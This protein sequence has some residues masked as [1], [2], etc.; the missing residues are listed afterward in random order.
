MEPLQRFAS[1]IQISTVLIVVPMFALTRSVSPGFTFWQPLFNPVSAPL[2]KHPAFTDSISQP[3]E[4]PPNEVPSTE[5][6]KLRFYDTYLTG[7]E[8]FLARN[9]SWEVTSDRRRDQTDSRGCK[10]AYNILCV[11]QIGQ[12]YNF[13]SKHV[14]DGGAGVVELE[15]FLWEGSRYAFPTYVI[16]WRKVLSAAHKGPPRTS[17]KLRWSR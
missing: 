3:V 13:Q 6:K 16:V 9:C 7:L 2:G 17:S 10:L 8:P 1:Q 4:I 14:Y 15:K 5:D 11:I 12:W